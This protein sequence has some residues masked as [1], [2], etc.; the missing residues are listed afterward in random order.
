MMS[1]SEFAIPV[2]LDTNVD[3]GKLLHQWIW[4]YHYN[5]PYIPELCIATFG[6]YGYA[7][8]PKQKGIEL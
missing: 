4:L 8:L 7:C 6:L 5:H 1:L 3:T 2:F